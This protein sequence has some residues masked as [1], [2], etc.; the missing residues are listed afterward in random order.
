MKVYISRV[1]KKNKKLTLAKNAKAAAVK[2]GINYDYMLKYGRVTE[3]EQDI[4]LAV[5]NPDTVFIKDSSD[6]GEWQKV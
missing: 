1:D 2:F 3:N 4:E 6:I 5:S